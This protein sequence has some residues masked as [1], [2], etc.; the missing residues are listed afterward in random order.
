MG[1]RE[2]EKAPEAPGHL[3]V[4]PQ[5]TAALGSPALACCW[6]HPVLSL[7]SSAKSELNEEHDGNRMTKDMLCPWPLKQ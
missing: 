1:T 6:A 2:A 7:P 5:Q 4:G 3:N